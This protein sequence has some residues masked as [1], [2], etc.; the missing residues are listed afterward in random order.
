M[1]TPAELLAAAH[2]AAL[3]D[4][5]PPPSPS[6]HVS[7]V[8][9]ESDFPALLTPPSSAPLSWPRSSL[10]APMRLNHVQ[11]AFSLDFDAQLNVSKPD[12][13]AILALVRQQTG[14]SIECTS[15]QQTRKRTF[16]IS[17]PRAKVAEAKSEIVRR[18]LKPVVVSF[19]IPQLVRGAVVGAGGRNVKALIERH[20]VKI[21]IARSSDP[22]PDP[23]LG[24]TVHVLVSG[25]AHGAAAAKAE[26]LAVVDEYTLNLSISVP[27]DLR[28]APHLAFELRDVPEL[29]DIDYDVLAAAVTLQGSREQVTE[30]RDAVLRT[31]SLLAKELAARDVSVPRSA[32]RFLDSA[33]LLERH[34]VA[35][36]VLDDRTVRFAGPRANIDAAVKTARELSA[37]H[38]VVGLNIGRAHDGNAAHGELLAKFFAE[39][40]EFE[41]LKVKV[42]FVGGANVEFVY[43][44]EPEYKKVRKALI[45]RVNQLL[46][47][48]VRGLRGVHPIYRE[49]AQ[50]ALEGAGATGITAVVAD[51][52][53]FVLD[54][55]LDLEE[56]DFGPLASEI[57]AKF[58]ELEAKLEA[59]YASS[60]SVTEVVVELP[61]EHKEHV[62]DHG[63]RAAKEAAAGPLLVT[64]QNNNL[65][66]AGA[67]T[68]VAAAEKEILQA[69]QDAR[70]YAQALKYT[71]TVDFPA[72]AVL[73]L[74]GK[75]GAALAETSR[76]F[77]VTIDV[78]KEGG[79]T[80]LVRITG[81]QR[82]ADAAAAH[83]TKNGAKWAD[84]VRQTVSVPKE[85]QRRLIGPKGA[86]VN[87]LQEKYGV[88]IKFPSEGQ[89]VVVR[90]PLKGVKSASGELRELL[91]YEIENGHKVVVEVAP[92]AISR[93][94]GKSGAHLNLL[95]DEYGVEID[96]RDGESRSIVEIVGTKSAIK[97]VEKKVRAIASEVENTVTELWEV[98]PAHYRAILGPNGLNLREILISLGASED[99]SQWRRLLTVPDR[100]S[101]LHTVTS[102]GPLQIVAEIVRRV[103]EIVAAEEALV[104]EQVNVPQEKHRLLI[105]PGGSVR[106]DIEAEFSVQVNIPKVSEKLSEITIK[107]LPENVEKAKQRV[108]KL[109]EDKWSESVDVPAK[110]HGYLSQN[111]GYFRKLRQNHNVTIEHGPQRKLAQKL[112]SGVKAPAEVSVGTENWVEAALPD[113]EGVIPWRIV[114]KPEDSAAAK[115]TILADLEAVLKYDTIGYYFFQDRSVFSKVIGPRGSV[116]GD[117]RK[118]C[119]VTI[120]V[121]GGQG[122][123][124][125][126]VVAG[127]K[128]G[129]EKAKTL[130]EKAIK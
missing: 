71:T 74:I 51:K 107:G 40:K 18:L 58:D 93:I 105:G 79:S 120:H 9:D 112:S 103:K 8:S 110:Y 99:S 84:E 90:G 34:N 124:N 5:S 102:T 20:H 37:R 22:V 31:A 16:L 30:A 123:D 42:D 29:A 65:H 26:I 100:G 54:P 47:V 76:E 41:E 128:S 96:V 4:D 3:R 53:I 32:H 43:D 39:T 33:A 60:D 75:G 48:R 35:V 64:E 109:T 45:E 77:G 24:E 72:N 114:G 62:L 87:R 92:E 19:A 21:D 126:I 80:V 61:E 98:D 117:I 113:H 15:S 73:R 6:R 13:L 67:A 50:K 11:E 44:D 95:R 59:I 125:V 28:V 23:V 127:E 94:I 81:V 78:A 57:A 83:I 101:K 118:S 97:D 38:K 129:V 89:E 106:R 86:Y 116:V 12:F 66:I 1:A 121:P 70:D 119:N 46:P 7:S 10:A 49:K 27:V 25:D 104:T 2:R 82:Q 115:K 91:N 14:C 122:S 17:G 108:A 63:V 111:G 68:D 85:Y 69:V 52:I 55:A 88:R 56:D 36:S 130:I